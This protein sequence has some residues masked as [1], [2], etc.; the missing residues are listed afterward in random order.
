MLLG[1]LSMRGNGGVLPIRAGVPTEEVFG[2]GVTSSTM[3][4]ERVSLRDARDNGR[5]DHR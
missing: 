4:E 5:D 1:G 3:A 2:K